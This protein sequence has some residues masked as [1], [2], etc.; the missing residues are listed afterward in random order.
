MKVYVHYEQGSDTDLHVTLKLTLPKKWEDQ[1][2]VRVLELFVDSYNKRKPDNRLVTAECHLEVSGKA[3]THGDTIGST[4]KHQGDVYVVP[5]ATEEAK[6]RPAEEENF[7]VVPSNALLTLAVEYLWVCTAK[8][9]GRAGAL[10]CRNFGCNEYFDEGKNS[11]SACRHHT[12]PPIFH[13]T[14]KGWGCC[15]KRVYDWDEFE[16]LVGC[17]VG[18]HDPTDPKDKLPPT[19]PSAEEETKQAAPIPLKSIDKFNQENPDA[20]TAAGS[21]VKALA[22]GSKKCT[23]RADGTACCINNGCQKDF[24]VSE[25]TPDS[26]R[27]HA[28]NPVFHDGGKHWACCPDQVKFEFEDFIAVQGCQLGYHNDGSGEFKN[29]VSG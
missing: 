21:V 13:D 22:K 28:M 19:P 29:E 3:L 27:Y 26:C 12:A 17:I 14:R 15:K 1:N 16:Q 5:G 10:R 11:D 4:M 7:I 8:G 25:N 18:R 20:A 2:P 23:R 6:T 24:T 9:T